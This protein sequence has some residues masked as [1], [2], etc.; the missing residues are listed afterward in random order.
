MEIAAAY[1]RVSTDDQTEYSPDSQI[2]V[3]QERAQ[4]D[5]YM[6]PEDLIFRD[7]AISGKR[8]DK[9]PQFMLLI[10]KAKE[11][12]P[13]FRR[14]YVWEFSRFARNMEESIVYKNLLRKKGITVQ[15][16][17]EP[18]ADSPFASLIERIIEWMDEYYLINLATEV[19]R[20][21]KEKA[22]RGEPIGSA[23]YGYK[24]DKESKSYAVDDTESPVVR[25][26]FSE[27]AGGRSLSGLTHDMN[28]KGFRTRSG[29]LW[30]R[31]AV[32]YL[33]SN[34]AYIGRT[35]WS[36]GGKANYSRTGEDSTRMT[37]YDAHHDPIV[38]E[39]TFRLVQQRLLENAEPHGWSKGEDYMLRGLIR[40][41]ACGSTLARTHHK[42]GRGNPGLQCVSYAAGKC[43]VSHSVTIPAAEKAILGYLE[44]VIEDGTFEY[45]PPAPRPDVAWDRM[46]AAEEKRIDRAKAAFL[47]G[48]FSAEEYRQA[49]ASAEANIQK[50]KA[51]DKKEAR[52]PSPAAERRKLIKVM[53]LLKSPTIDATA[54]N[55]ALHTVIDHIVY[56]RPERK[57]TV[58]FR[59]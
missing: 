41:S 13:G 45:V 7:D 51:A 33:L 47:D 55:E 3:I 2:A 40:C 48:T 37:L 29:N 9:R 6:I 56:N 44:Q 10:A 57:F 20:G 52:L 22:S 14:I 54:K 31:R 42:P 28:E 4:K 34:P 1:V 21:L 53:D 46:I 30:E 50:L 5:G 24:Y 27:Y 17:K 32:K 23:P 8:A 35:R 43:T 36:A 59:P 19:S 58:Y 26:A 16:V 12:D 11:P 38:D 25:Y 39:E 18:L 15:S 49:K